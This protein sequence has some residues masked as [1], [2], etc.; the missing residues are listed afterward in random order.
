MTD[1]LHR[2]FCIR[3]GLLVIPTV[4]WLLLFA[5]LPQSEAV[6]A[7]LALVC[8]ALM[9]W[10]WRLY[11]KSERGAHFVFLSLLVGGFALASVWL[12]LNVTRYH[13]YDGESGRSHVHQ[14]VVS[15]QD[16][17][18]WVICALMAVV[19]VWALFHFARW[20]SG[21]LRTN[22]EISER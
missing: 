12:L 19:S 2:N 22:A 18:V 7:I 13:T 20:L 15:T 1:S 21:R 17:L 9:L 16:R 10:Q 3:H 5:G 8:I 11:R 6:R 4:T 14:M